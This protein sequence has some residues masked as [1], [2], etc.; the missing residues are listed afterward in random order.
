M[1]EK[2][3]NIKIRD[4]V[5]VRKMEL[6]KS[7]YDDF[8][9]WVSDSNNLYIGRNMSFYIPGAIQSK[10]H[11]PFVV[12]KEKYTIEESL[13]KYREHILNSELYDELHELDGKTL[14]CWCKPKKC[15]GDI[16]RELATATE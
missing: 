2:N 15:H 11:N 13:E 8:K 7:G 1:V 10:W 14:G 12:A 3:N 16:L 6:N 9:Q 5:N 4:I